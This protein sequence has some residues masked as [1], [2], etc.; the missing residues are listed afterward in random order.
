MSERAIDAAPREVPTERERGNAMSRFAAPLA[1]LVVLAALAGCM[2]NGP[3][4]PPLRDGR[5]LWSAD[6]ESGDFKAFQG[7]PATVAGAKPPA[8]VTSPVRE[9]RYALAVAVPGPAAPP[10]GGAQLLPKF[11]E[12]EP[13]DDLWFGFSTYLEP[14]FPTDPSWQSILQFKQ[15]FDGSPPL[16]LDLAQGNWLIEGGV[17]HPGGGKPFNLSVAPATTGVWADW[18]IHVVFSPDPKIGLVEVW[19]NGAPVINSYA[20]ATGTMYHNPNGNDRS[21]VKLGYHRRDTIAEPG[22]VVF[23]ELRIGTTMGSVRHIPDG[24]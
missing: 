13:G 5:L 3:V 23:D 7:V 12:L 18:A 24:T 14:G 11:R 17:D 9:G 19:L 1:I 2:V 22:T 8:L 15:N 10:A 16:G 4:T 6:L 20:P 21:Y